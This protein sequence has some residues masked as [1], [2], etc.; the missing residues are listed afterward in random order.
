[1]FCILRCLHLQVVQASVDVVEGVEGNRDIALTSHLSP[2]ELKGIVIWR[3]LFCGQPKVRHQGKREGLPCSSYFNLEPT[4]FN[5]TATRGHC[6]DSTELEPAAEVVQTN[7]DRTTICSWTRFRLL[8]WCWP[9]LLTAI[10]ERNFADVKPYGILRNKVSNN[11][12]AAPGKLA[13]VRSYGVR[14]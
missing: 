3:S 14:R 4:K 7:C 8:G 13:S 5:V 6:L 10:W 12:G 2:A 11:L 1:M 9:W